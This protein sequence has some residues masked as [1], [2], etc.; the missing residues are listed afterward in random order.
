MEDSVE[1]K[2]ERGKLIQKHRDSV[3]DLIGSYCYQQ[4]IAHMNNS[5]SLSTALPMTASISAISQIASQLLHLC[6]GMKLYQGG[7]FATEA[8]S[9]YL[10]ERVQRKKRMKAKLDFFRQ[11]Q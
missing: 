2:E 1:T 8:M 5:C 6:L 9:S 3:V 10:K 11:K 4:K 7:I